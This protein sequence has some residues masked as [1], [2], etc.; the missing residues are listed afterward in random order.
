MSL[1]ANT[2]YYGDCLEWLPSFPSESVDL[3]YLDP[4]FN[5]NTDY[6]LLFGNGKQSERNGGK[7][8]QVKA[9]DDTWRWDDSAEDRVS[10]LTKATAHPAHRAVVGLSVM[11]PAG[12]MLAYLS[13]MAERLAAMPRILKPTGSIFLHCDDK[14]SHGLKLVMDVI[15]GPGNFR[16][17]IIWQRRAD[18]HN[19]ATKHMGRIHDVVLYYVRS[20]AA[21]YRKQFQPYDNSYLRSHYKH[22]GHRGRYRLCPVAN[23]AGGNKPYEFRGVEGAWRYTRERMQAMYDDGLLYQSGPGRPW[24][25]KKFLADAEGVPLQ[26]LWTDIKPVRGKKQSLGYPTQK[27]DPLLERII[28]ASTDEG[29]MVLDPFCGC[30]TAVAAAHKLNRKWA[31]ID[32]SPFAIDLIASKRFHGFKVPTEGYPYDLAGA[33]KLAK[34][35]PFK[36]E[37]WAVTRVPG[38]APNDKQVGDHGIDGVGQLLHDPSEPEMTDKVLAQVKGGRYQLKEV[39]DFLHVVNRE[40]AATGLYTTVDPIRA[41]GARSE[42]RKLG[43]FRMGASKYPRAQLW[44]IRDYFEDRFPSLPALADPYTGKPAQIPLQMTL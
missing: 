16:N 42:V 28:A 40:H 1:Q 17:E 37:K 29:D 7:S 41:A 31:G 23:K 13:Y 24:Q 20:D 22:R 21:R 11:L 14:A 10:R 43:T 9:F 39:R 5:S 33:R 36:F 35:A 34:D 27:P 30:G 44:S 26:D 38:L 15:F 12:G 4:P 18:K 25:Y 19:L 6:N 32:I 3:I 8:A 2:L